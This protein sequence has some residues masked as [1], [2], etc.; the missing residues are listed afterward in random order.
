MALGKKSKQ[1]KKNRRL[2][3]ESLEP[4]VVLTANT[5][6]SGAEYWVTHEQIPASNTGAVSYLD[7]D[8]YE[9]F[10]VDV[11]DL[12]SALSVAP[13][14]FTADASQPM[15][16]EIPTPSGGSE[17][18]AVVESPIMAPELAAQ[19]PEIKTYAG[20]SL[21]NPGSVVRFDVT[22][23]GFHAQVRTAD[24][25]GGY[26]VDPYYHLENEVHVSYHREALAPRDQPFHE[27][28]FDA[29][30][31]LIY[32]EVINLADGTH[33]HPDGTVHSNADH[34]HLEDDFH[35]QLFGGE[36]SHEDGHV[37]DHNH[38]H[39]GDGEHLHNKDD[40]N[41][42]CPDCIGL[43]PEQP[44]DLTDNNDDPQI[45]LIP[46]TGSELRIYR[47]AVAATGE[48]TQFHGGTVAGGQAAIVTMMNRVTGVYE[49]ELTVRMTL[50]PNNS[51][52]VYTNP[53]S[54]P[55]PN[56]ISLNTI[57]NVIN[58]NIGFANYD[59]GH[60]VDTGGGG[61]AG[62]GVIGTSQKAFGYTGLTPP[63]NDPFWIDFV[64]HE[65]GHQYGGNHTFNGD[66]GSCAGGN[67][68]GNSAYEPGSG[69]TIMAYAG[70]CGN[71]NLQ[72]NSDAY[73]HS[74]SLDEIINLL[75][76]P[77]SGV[78]TRVATGNSIPTAD[79]GSNF[80]IP[81]DTPFVLTG[82]GTDADGDTLTY[83]WEQRDLGPQRDVNAPD[84]G[85]SPLFR[86][87][88][89]NTDP[90]RTLPRLSDLVRNRT[91][92]GEQLP[93]TNRILD[94][95]LTVRDNRADG[96]A[97]ATDDTRISVTTAADPFRVTVPNTSSTVWEQNSTETVTWDVAGTTG[98][99]ID[100][101]TVNILLS[102][103]GGFTYPITLAANTPNDGS[104]DIVVPNEL[105]T[106]ARVKV[107]AV[108]NI[109]FDISDSDF[110]IDVP[111]DMEAPT[112][113][114]TAADITTEGI[115]SNLVTVVYSDNEGIDAS[116]TGP[117][118]I[119][120]VAPDGTVTPGIFLSTSSATDTTPITVTYVYAAPGGTFDADDLGTH[121]IV[122]VANEITDVN[123]IPVAAGVIGSFEVSFE[124][125]TVDGD[126][127]NDGDYD[128]DDINSL[129]TEV[130][131]GT[132]DSPVRLE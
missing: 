90:T 36:H 111:S 8:S 86:S 60:L 58:A 110:D 24:G 95:R 25:T 32:S 88:E 63:V 61:F 112:A 49:D 53:G 68:A 72:N 69:S 128:C 114:A 124:T 43:T 65:L 66:S 52:I 59:L 80:T 62:L 55:F 38:S 44:T 97:V 11:D 26:Y 127:D 29:N 123:D 89:P 125:M 1:V 105:T 107:E 100:T 48:Y 4:R 54:D 50:V 116:D 41:C 76:G 73:F 83:N 99:G 115:P 34:M 47:T 21:D 101:A 71:D 39:D 64:A 84:N 6:T 132:N 17:T 104:Q 70:I 51:D 102:L 19:F 109:F 18:F 22:P 78:G 2:M 106:E 82:S 118:D 31:E 103:D 92:R 91:V 75:D 94:F 16:F 85:S 7:L 56:N 77:R 120:F 23:H 45:D 33:V 57:Q 74:R 130:G 15:T 5:L 126:F 27:Q 13:M 46:R 35:S 121:D 9:S 98:N 10:S 42:C 14:E 3:S 67:R 12:R 96:G 113:V 87:W 40:E 93:T 37:H 122:M 20:Q 117:G 119:E 79:A 129:T 81:P 30:G 108:G 131:A 28:L